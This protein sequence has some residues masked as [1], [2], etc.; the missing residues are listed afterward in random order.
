M[1]KSKQLSNMNKNWRNK[2]HKTLVVPPG[3]DGIGSNYTLDD[4][5]PLNPYECIVDLSLTYATPLVPLPPS[6]GTDLT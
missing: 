1:V 4:S 2:K 5:K 3:K 6:E